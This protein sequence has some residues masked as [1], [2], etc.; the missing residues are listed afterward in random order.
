MQTNTMRTIMLCLAAAMLFVGCEQAPGPGGEGDAA[1]EYR[2]TMIIFDRPGNAFWAKVV[3]G[4]KETSALLGC[5]TDVQYANGDAARQND[6]IETAIANGVDGIG[7][8]LNYDDAYDENVKRAVD[9]GIGVIAF[10]IDDTQRGAGNA[11]MAYIGQDMEEAGELIAARL[12]AEAGL[13]E[14]DHVLCPVEYPD[15]VYAI[16]RYAGVSRVLNKHG[17]G[18]EVL[19]TGATSVDD[20][21]NKITQ[22]LIGHKET[23]AICA[24]GQMPMEASPQA[25]KDAGLEL[26]IAGFDLSTQIARDISEGRSI[27]TVDQQPFYQGCLTLTQLYFHSKYGLHPC[28]INTGGSMVDASNVAR[29]MDLADTVR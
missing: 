21:L 17:I 11:R 3:A 9:A 19:S 29:V 24:M 14:G 15:A 1:S 8:V 20:V 7:V 10:N 23:D 16:Q 25:A 2:F 28:D 26:P 27:A 13:E 12:V 4:V 18:S 6:I 5:D 22:Y